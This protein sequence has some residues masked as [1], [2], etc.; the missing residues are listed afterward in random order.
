MSLHIDA[1]L[2][3]LARWRR[4]LP[5]VTPA[6]LFA[7]GLLATWLVYQQ[8]EQNQQAAA[9]ARF[10]REIE[11]TTAAIAARMSAYEDL[12]HSANA[13]FASDESV[14]REQWR[15]FVGALPLSTTIP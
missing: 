1:S 11:R 2:R 13:L 4:W 14:S 10:D 7:L 15:T 8:L 6:V 12:L 5:R 3:T 9:R